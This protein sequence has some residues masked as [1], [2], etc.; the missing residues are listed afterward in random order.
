M[1]EVTMVVTCCGRVDL[2]E[3]TLES[4]F[5]HNTYPVKKVIITED[6][7][8]KQ[9]FQKVKSLVNCDLTIIENSTNIGQIAS[10][11]KAYSLVDTDYIFHCEEDW[12]FYDSGF[13]E[14]SF[15]ILATNSKLFTVWLRAHNDTKNHAILFDEKFDLS[16]NDYYYLMDGARKKYWCGFTFNPGLRR[17]HDCMIFHPYNDLEVRKEKNNMLIMG[18]IDLSIYYQELGYRAAI[19]SKE[20]GYVKHIGGKRH[21]PLPWQQ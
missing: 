13:I 11:D 5:K 7:G 21:I 10:I 15:E 9:N 17:T 20:T 6:S 3:I 16:N 4:F 12:Q 8:I 18:E 14:K 19:T 1:N 2:L